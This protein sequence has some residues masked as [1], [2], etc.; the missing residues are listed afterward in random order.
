[1]KPHILMLWWIQHSIRKN[2]YITVQALEWNPQGK[3]KPGRQRNSWRRSVTQKMRKFE[4]T[5][6]EVENQPKCKWVKSW[7]PF[8]LFIIKLYT[9]HHTHNWPISS[10]QK[11]TLPL[12]LLPSKT[13][14]LNWTSLLPW[15]SQCPRVCKTSRTQ[16][17]LLHPL[18]SATYKYDTH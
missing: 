12:F 17:S 15:Y 4:P 9:P 6:K 14:H 7:I 10:M 13:Q 18:W 2:C 11:Y 16:S 1:M 5:W 8:S 3:R